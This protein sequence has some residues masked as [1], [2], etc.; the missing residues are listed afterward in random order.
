MATK[1]IANT[2]FSKVTTTKRDFFITLQSIFEEGGWS[3]IASDPS[4]EG[5]IFYSKGLSGDQDIIVQFTDWY[6]R[7]STNSPKSDA[8]S[9]SSNV[10]YFG[11][12]ALMSYEP[13]ED[14]GVPGI[15]YP[16]YNNYN[17]QRVFRMVMNQSNLSPSARMDLYYLVNKDRLVL[18]VDLVD[19]NESTWLMVGRFSPT[20]SAIDKTR[21]TVLLGNN[22]QHN[23][24]VSMTR[25]Y[26]V[27]KDSYYALNP[28][29]QKVPRS[30]TEQNQW[31]TEL[32]VGSEDDGIKGYVDGL[33]ALL[34]DKASDKTFRTNTV[35][36]HDSIF[37]EFNNEYKIFYC[38]SAHPYISDSYYPF[39]TENE[40]F[41]VIKIKDGELM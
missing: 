10:I 24:A 25:P 22:M 21:G 20:I 12:K 3:E 13:N 35:M 7:E 31:V 29:Y 4:T 14:L 40:Y 30:I 19:L 39:L 32:A 27:K 15:A 36:H 6:L 41:Y 8:F 23:H 11:V 5:K 9:T 37:D 28:F 26:V 33:Y 34:P 17:Y 2:T 38:P 1:N 16:K 18:L